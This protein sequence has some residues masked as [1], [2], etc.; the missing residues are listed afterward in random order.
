[1]PWMSDEKY[2]FVSDVRDK[3]ITARSAHRTRTHNGKGGSV[4][5]PSDF[6]SRKELKAMNGPVES[7]RMNEPMPWADFKKMPDDLKK[8]YITAIRDR[9]GAPDSAIAKML[10]CSQCT[11]SLWLR[12]LKCSGAHRTGKEKWEKEKFYAWM[13]GASTDAVE[14]SPAE[15]D[16]TVETVET[17]TCA[18]EKTD[19]ND[20]IKV[21]ESP[22]EGVKKSEE[23]E[24]CNEKKCAIPKT[25]EMSFAGSIDDILNT[26]GLLLND[27]NVCLEV[28]WTTIDE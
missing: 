25:G 22:V 26:I 12:D 27:A 21:T 11:L 20:A 3:S 13:S 14:E 7:F 16:E 2:E 1:M 9:F 18:E 28:K 4:K 24:C 8:D 10:G 15:S 5:F 23:S 6:M 17:V 19:V